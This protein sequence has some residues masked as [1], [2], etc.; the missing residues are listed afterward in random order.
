MLNKEK[1][2]EYLNL[3][4]DRKR[5]TGKFVNEDYYEIPTLEITSII[6]FISFT[7]F[8]CQVNFPGFSPKYVKEEAR[9]S[10]KAN[11]KEQVKKIVKKSKSERVREF[12]ESLGLEGSC[13][14]EVAKAVEPF[15]A[16]D[17]TVAGSITHTILSRFTFPRNNQ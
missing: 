7:L 13:L 10:E 5:K 15:D 17:T 16:E 9:K 14:V 12:A 11:I 8:F 6:H 2:T 3:R 4:A 1:F